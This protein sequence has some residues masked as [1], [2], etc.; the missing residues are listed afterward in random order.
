MRIG[1]ILGIGV[2]LA[3][4]L[5]GRM[6]ASVEGRQVPSGVGYGEG[7]PFPADQ[8]VWGAS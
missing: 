2:D 8:G 3:R 1:R 5:G 6:M 4:F 7:C